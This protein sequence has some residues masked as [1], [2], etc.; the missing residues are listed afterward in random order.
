MRP[1]H[2]TPVQSPF[3]DSLP[4]LWSGEGGFLRKSV[5]VRPGNDHWTIGHSIW[6]LA[7]PSN[8]VA[9]EPDLRA[10]LER[11]RPAGRV[12]PKT[13]AVVRLV[14][15]LVSQGCATY[16]GSRP[17]YTLREIRH[18]VSASCNQ[19][20][21]TYYKHPFWAQISEC[22]LSLAQLFAWAL[23]TY[24]LSRSA[25]PTAS[26]GAIHSRNPLA[27][28]AF[29]K[30]A[31]EE[32]AHCESY[33]LPEH[34]AFGL[35]REWIATLVPTASS[36]AFDQQMSVIA[37]AD[38]LAHTWVGFFQ[39][40]TASFREQAFALYGRLEAAYQ[41]PGFFDGW[42]DHI[43]YDVDHTHADD[44]ADLFIGTT[45]VARDDLD[46]SL[47][48]ATATIEYLIGALDE[49]ADLPSALDLNTYR[50][51]PHRCRIGIGTDLLFGR[52]GDVGSLLAIETTEHLC[53]ALLERAFGMY[54]ER[55]R[56]RTGLSSAALADLAL[57]AL[58]LAEAHHDI[59][60]LGKWVD[61][62]LSRSHGSYGGTEA[63]EFASAGARALSNFIRENARHA[64]VVLF[65]FELIE[66]LEENWQ[67]RSPFDDLAARSVSRDGSC[68]ELTA[69]VRF[70]EILVTGT[71]RWSRLGADDLL[72]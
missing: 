51:P 53:R 8:V 6:E 55:S 47:L 71:R 56:A 19:W 42:R 36:A 30:S 62:Y 23:R 72:G 2:I 17:S 49:L 58:S 11:S 7:V 22:R 15:L 9:S 59:I 3:A 13:S 40:Y 44:F 35:D 16:D 10:F 18:L 27:R 21:G 48:N 14:Q 65:L 60:L 26:R 29:A 68:L 66:M 38:W 63:I 34:P 12:E 5:V 64:S 24:H 54:S 37:E 41:L 52:L 1:V 69:G 67:E 28:V 4:G 25:G 45:E 43:G 57:R 46:R 39:E 50:V 61:I 20:Y 33:Y 70:L 32:Y 31:V